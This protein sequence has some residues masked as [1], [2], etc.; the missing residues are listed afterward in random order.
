MAKSCLGHLVV[1]PA[2]S[3][4]WVLTVLTL[5]PDIDGP[6]PAWAQPSKHF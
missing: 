2:G 1:W 6:V 4:G 5:H 3:S